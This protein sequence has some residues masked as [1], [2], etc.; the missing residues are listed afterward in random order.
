LDTG[1]SGI[2]IDTEVGTEIHG[3][4]LGVKIHG[5]EMLPRQIHLDVDT[6]MYTLN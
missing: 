4:D 1:W 6:Y 3:V 2:F 5:V